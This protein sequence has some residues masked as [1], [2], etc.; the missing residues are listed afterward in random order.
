[1]K[2]WRLTNAAFHTKIGF[3]YFYR[4]G[5]TSCF[6]HPKGNGKVVQVYE[7]QTEV[8]VPGTIEEIEVEDATR[9]QRIPPYKVIF[10]NDDVTTMDF[11]IHVLI[12]LFKKDAETAVRLM[13]EVHQLGSA[14][15]DIL[16]LEEAELRQH[17]V[18][19]AARG[20]RFP[21]RCV[22]EPA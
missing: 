1:M 13:L 18:H 12:T 15:V 16:P 8:A 14:V 20:A 22:I 9:V 3:S 11:V 5:Q 19:E 21:L 6:Y 10:L 2:C 17:Q 7:A 4:G